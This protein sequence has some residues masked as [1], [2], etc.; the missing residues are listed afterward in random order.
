MH[1]N[2]ALNKTKTNTAILILL[3]PRPIKN[4]PPH[5]EKKAV[6]S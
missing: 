5:V 1:K 4:M 2:G 6:V 3:P